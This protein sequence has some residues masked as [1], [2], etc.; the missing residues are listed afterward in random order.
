[1]STRVKMPS[2]V[3]EPRQPSSKIKTP[4]EVLKVQVNKLYDQMQEDGFD[5]D[6]IDDHCKFIASYIE[7]NGWSIDDY[8]SK[9]LNN[10]F[11]TLN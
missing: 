8:V 10:D 3:R 6:S 7:N 9:D 4:F 11:D 1:M 2:D 5:M